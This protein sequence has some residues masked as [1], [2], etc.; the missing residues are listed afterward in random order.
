V[1]DIRNADGSMN[2]LNMLPMGYHV[3]FAGAQTP[4]MDYTFPAGVALN[5]PANFALDFNTH[6]VNRGSDAITGEAFANLY[7][8]DASAVQNVAKT[9]NLP[10]NSISLPAGQRT[11]LTKEFTLPAGARIFMLTSHMHQLGERFRI[12]IKGGA[13]DGQLL[14]ETTD[15][16]HPDIKTFSP[17]LQLG[18]NERIVS[19]ITWNN[20][21]SHVVN[22]G[23]TSSDEMGIVFGYYY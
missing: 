11:T 13:R 9:L 21:T 20:T 23:L 6:F 7:T 4:E 17:V 22:F 12:L 8:V 15:W 3:F 14:Y 10:N 5:L 18:A 19:E 1:R 2:V 16:T